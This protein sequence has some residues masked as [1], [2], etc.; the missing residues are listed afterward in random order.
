VRP[1]GV[2]ELATS[3]VPEQG[4]HQPW[5]HHQHEPR[6]DGPSDRVVD[7]RALG[8]VERRLR[9]GEELHIS[10]RVDRESTERVVRIDLGDTRRDLADDDVH[11]QPGR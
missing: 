2:N 8:H 1:H 10:L 9:I 7:E 5:R 6:E 4:T 3:S 11:S